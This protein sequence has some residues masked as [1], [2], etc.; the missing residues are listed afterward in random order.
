MESHL[1]KVPRFLLTSVHLYYAVDMVTALQNQ[2]PLQLIPLLKFLVRVSDGALVEITRAAQCCW[3]EMLIVQ[4]NVAPSANG[5]V[6][7]ELDEVS[8]R[9]LGPPISFRQIVLYLAERS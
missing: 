4:D 1:D 8:S 5:G 3:E 7:S 6:P 2:V 9:L